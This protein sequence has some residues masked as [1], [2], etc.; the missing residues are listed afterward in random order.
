MTQR[1]LILSLL[2]IGLL[3]FAGCSA[4][5][6]NNSNNRGNRGGDFAPTVEAIQARVGALPLEERLSGVVRAR[7][8]TVIY[9]EIT[10]PVVE[11]LVND[12]D[13]VTKG[14]SLVRLRDR[15]FRE[16]VRQ[17]ES[18]LQIANA[19]VKQAETNLVQAQAALQRILT[20]SERDLGTQVEMERLRAELASAEASLSLAKAQRDQVSS[21]LEERKQ[22]LENT[23]V[24]SPVTG[25]VGR[26][27]AEVGQQV[28]PNTMLFEVG[29]LSVVE[30]Q[31]NLTERML[32]YIEPGMNAAV[33]SQAMT[34]TLIRTNLTRISPFLDPVA[35]ST[36][37][38]LVIDNEGG[39]L[40]PG[41]FVTVDIFYGE[42]DQAALIPNNAIYNHP[43][44][45]TRGVYILEASQVELN[46]GGEFAEGIYGPFPAQFVPVEIVAEGRMVSGVRGINSGDWVVTVGQNLLA[47]GRTQAR[48]RPMNW[49]RMLELQGMQSQDII[50]LIKEKLA[51][52]QYQ[53]ADSDV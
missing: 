9:S 13:A 21:Q 20:L 43:R 24:V 30:V 10:A 50:R 7:N 49:D 38:Q 19:Q 16:R 11:V 22:E 44:Q 45:G 51:D 48:F 41:M 35:H 3:F 26:R 4:G 2:S 53:S 52:Q 37:G 18:G 32:G 5:E 12:G 34:D 31:I 36:Q 39:L 6:E 1:I 14:Q 17:A 29:D 42:S 8:Q 47:T 25:V 23:V 27:N 15:S 28:T 46:A 40:R 33:Y